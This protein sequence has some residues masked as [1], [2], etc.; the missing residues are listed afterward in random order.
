ML[1]IPPQWR[2]ICQQ[3]K[4]L[5]KYEISLK[6]WVKR[7]EEF[8][9]I[10]SINPVVIFNKPPPVTK[11]N[12]HAIK[13]ITYL[14][15]YNLIFRFYI[16]IFWTTKSQLWYRNFQR[17][18]FIRSVAKAVQYYMSTNICRWKYVDNQHYNE[19]PTIPTARGIILHSSP[20]LQEYSI[21]QYAHHTW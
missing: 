10:L 18:V 20:K 11:L 19:E 3:L 14:F 17:P 13:Q 8:D 9:A 12:C 1:R 2:K 5:H 6:L 21:R 4:T 7:Y 16:C 15:L